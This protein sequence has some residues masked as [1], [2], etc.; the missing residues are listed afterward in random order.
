MHL[1]VKPPEQR[2]I[3]AISTKHN[4]LTNNMMLAKRPHE[5][6]RIWVENKLF[7]FFFTKPTISGIQ[8]TVIWKAEFYQT[9]NRNLAISVIDSGPLITGISLLIILWF[10][11]GMSAA[12]F[13][14]AIVAILGIKERDK[15]SDERTAIWLMI[16]L[17]SLISFFLLKSWKATKC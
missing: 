4:K 9:I 5:I 14:S 7:V 12:K 16:L 8:S 6:L 15:I 1:S 3:S 11:W 2:T 10:G 13:C 17:L